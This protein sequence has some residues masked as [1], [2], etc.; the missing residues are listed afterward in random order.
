M[1]EQFRGE[2]SMIRSEG[3]LTTDEIHALFARCFVAKLVWFFLKVDGLPMKYT[4]YLQ[5]VS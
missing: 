3:R 1:E 5:A 2:I 4:P